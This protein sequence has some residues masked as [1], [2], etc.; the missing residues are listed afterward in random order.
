MNSDNFKINL[1][2]NIWSLIVAII[3]LGLS[4]FYNLK[5]T[6]LFGFLLSFLSLISFTITLYSYTLNYF[7]KKNKLSK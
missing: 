5:Y 1:N 3:T 2:Q 4:E 6:F 7:I